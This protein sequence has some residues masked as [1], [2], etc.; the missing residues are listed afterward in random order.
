MTAFDK[1]S[2]SPDEQLSKLRSRGLIIHD[3]PRVLRYLSNI[4]YFRLSAY[5]RPFYISSQVPHHF[6]PETTF[7][8]ILTLYVFDRK[9]RLLLLDAIERLE[10]ALRGLN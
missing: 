3:E 7:D 5:T 6:I 4:S 8:D 2:I 1:E 9:L 10:V